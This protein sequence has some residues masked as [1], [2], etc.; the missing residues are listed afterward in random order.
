M[1]ESGGL[2]EGRG[3]G[4]AEGHTT[5]ISCLYTYYNNSS[6]RNAL[7]SANSRRR[8]WGGTSDGLCES[9]GLSWGKGGAQIRKKKL[10]GWRAECGVFVDRAVQR[11]EERERRGPSLSPRVLA[12]RARRLLTVPSL[13]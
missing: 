5:R 1:H 2:R 13:E 9:A 7:A 10:G 4:H 11:S 6:L 12:G 3:G 8:A